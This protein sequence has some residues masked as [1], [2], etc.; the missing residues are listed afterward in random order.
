MN[1]LVDKYV[2]LEN[3]T[4]KEFK[5]RYKPQINDNILRKIDEKN[6]NKQDI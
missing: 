5:R 1:C 3:I 4:Q 6:K 2:P